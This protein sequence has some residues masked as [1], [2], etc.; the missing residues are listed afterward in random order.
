MNAIATLVRPATRPAPLRPSPAIFAVQGFVCD[1]TPHGMVGS[2]LV[3]R[4]VGQ[5]LGLGTVHLGEPSAP[6]DL[7]WHAALDRATP[8]LRRVAARLDAAM[9]EGARPLVFANRCGASIATIPV[10]LK[11]H[12]DAVVVW[13]DTHAD[14]NTPE[15]TPTGY[16]GG[17]VLTALCRL[18]ESGHGAGLTPDRIVLAGVRDIDAEEQVL[19]D[20]HGVRNIAPVHGALDVDA[21]VA[22]IGDRP[23]WLHIDCDVIDPVYVPAEYHVPGGLTP[24][25]LR[26]AVRAIA[27][28]CELIGFELT[29]FEAPEDAD[30]RAVALDTILATI[31]PALS[32]IG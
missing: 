20:R 27:E 24:A 2:G 31:E 26:R 1:R 22:A 19:M 17:M 18:W 5:R 4:H 10:A 28:R 11:Y 29:E 8:F 3:A 30:A 14:F 13:F 15:S 6:A 32:R 12:P 16:L 23:V 25:G 9:A 7:A 21:L